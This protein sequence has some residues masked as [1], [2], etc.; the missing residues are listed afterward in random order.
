MLP[1]RAGGRNDANDADDAH[2]AC[3][4][5]DAC[6][7]DSYLVKKP[8]WPAPQPVKRTAFK[9]YGT[10]LARRGSGFATFHGGVLKLG[11]GRRQPT[12]FAANE[13]ISATSCQVAMP[14]IKVE[15][16]MIPSRN[17]RTG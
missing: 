15:K 3:G 4:V 9:A 17:Y 11:P 13:S 6:D 12:R 16:T 5:C 14:T 2:D 1:R 10:T 8:R 7:A